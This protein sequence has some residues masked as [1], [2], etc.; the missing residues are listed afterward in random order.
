MELNNLIIKIA[1]S[2]AVIYIAI[3]LMMSEIKE[4]REAREKF[5]RRDENV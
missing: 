5:E 2:I 3:R 1:A 4:E